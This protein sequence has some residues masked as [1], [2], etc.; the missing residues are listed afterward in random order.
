MSKKYSILI[1]IFLLIF[2]FLISG[3]TIAGTE[4]NVEGWAW[5]EN[6][7]W[8]SFNCLNQNS[9]GTVNY[10]VNL[11]PSTK[12]FSGYAWS[13]NVGW[14]TFN[15][16]QLSG[17]P[18]A[19]CR[20]W[21][22]SD[23]KVYGWARALANGGGWDG[24]ISLR[25][26]SK[27][28]GVWLDTST[29]PQ[30]FRGFAWSDMVIG[31]ISFNCKNQNVC[32]TSSYKVFL[33]NKPPTVSNPYETQD[34]CAW[35]PS[36]QTAKGLAII[37]HWKYSDPEGDPSDGYE[38]WID[39]DSN[40]HNN[41]PRF[42]YKVEGIQ[43]TSYTVNLSD[44]QSTRDDKLTYPLSWNTTYYWKVRVKDSVGNWSD[45]SQVDS[46][47]LPSHASPYVDFNWFPP[48]PTVNEIVQFTDFSEC[49]DSSDNIVPC[50]SWYWTFQNGDP[51]ISTSKN[52]TTTFTSVGRNLVT[53][54]VTDPSG[55]WCEGSKTVTS[56]YPLPF[57]K[58][59]PPTIFKMRDFLASLI[60]RF[61]KIKFF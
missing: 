58:E 27:N 2:S 59:I 57:W 19:P 15:E 10:G 13:E 51:S 1:T 37:L 44:N 12:I 42:K 23:N 29:F 17:C 30:E 48:K 54:K 26:D 39:T 46:F 34:C 7:G 25:N 33:I 14:I 55:F 53:L 60:S 16:S 28:Y 21:L 22:G 43:S 49:Y 24:W 5:S 18:Q 38:V 40:F 52:P 50:N 3:K 61:S 35:G 4:H 56:L 41:D 47:T 32:S 8:I 6:V 45:W 20:A 36:P 9:C 11:N 31:W